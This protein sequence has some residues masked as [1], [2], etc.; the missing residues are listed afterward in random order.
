LLLLLLLLLLLFLLLLF[1]LIL[2]RALFPRIPTRA[3]ALQ[4]VQRT[5]CSSVSPTFLHCGE[6]FFIVKNRIFT[7]G[8]CGGLKIKTEVESNVFQTKSFA[9]SFRSVRPVQQ[10]CHCIGL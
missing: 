3:F 5:V 8:V 9:Y 1:L 7:G 4:P 10:L 2:G 6:V